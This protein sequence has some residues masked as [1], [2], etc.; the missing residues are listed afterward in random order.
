MTQNVP[1]LYS[2]IVRA[3]GIEK[4]VFIFFETGMFQTQDN[5]KDGIKVLSV[6]LRVLSKTPKTPPSFCGSMGVGF[7]N[8]HC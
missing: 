5:S 1:K 2:L 6:E 4:Y 7:R 8:E 3:R